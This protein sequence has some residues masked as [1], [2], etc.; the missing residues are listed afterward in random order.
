[1]ELLQGHCPSWYVRTHTLSLVALQYLVEP[2]CC[3]CNRGITIGDWRDPLDP[4][5]DAQ[6]IYSQFNKGKE[7]LTAKHATKE[8]MTTPTGDGEQDGG[9]ATPVP[10]KGVRE[11]EMTRKCDTLLEI[12][13]EL[14]YIHSTIP[15]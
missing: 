15:L 2:G 7:T 3:P 14:A 8:E 9:T 4:Y 12:L 5:L 11:R 13:E 6:V 1:M 10:E